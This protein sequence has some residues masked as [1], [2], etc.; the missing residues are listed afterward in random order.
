MN[1]G[2]CDPQGRLWAGTLADDFRVGGGALYRLD[3]NG[4]VELMLSDLTISNGLGWSPDGATMYLADSGPRV[5]HAFDFDGEAGTISEGRVLVGITKRLAHRMAL[6]SMP[7]VTC[8]LRSTG[9]DGS[10]AIPLM[11]R[12]GRRSCSP[13]CKAPRARSRAPASTVFT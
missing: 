12:C 11:E 5:I 10:S 9:A 8:G 7:K 2:A 1:D 13:R 3:G 4:R 6:P